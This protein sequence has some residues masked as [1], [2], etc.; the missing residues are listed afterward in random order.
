[1]NKCHQEDA[2]VA[3]F[4][5][6]GREV[7]VLP[8]PHFATFLIDNSLQECNVT[9]IINLLRYI[10]PAGICILQVNQYS[11]SPNQD[12]LP[13]PDFFGKY[14]DTQIRIRARRNIFFQMVSND[15][16]L[17]FLFF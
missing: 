1:M 5:S 2:I 17:I 3:Y 7:V 12:W 9:I 6:A 11:A 4:K 16:F 13:A 15:Y 8:C 14:T 10:I